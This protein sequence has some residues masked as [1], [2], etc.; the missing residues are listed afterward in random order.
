[1]RLPWIDA[2]IVHEAA[3]G[4]AGTHEGAEVLAAET[5]LPVSEGTR[6]ILRAMSRRG[7]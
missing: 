4:R 2:V 6:R 7:L 5:D 1:M 3:E